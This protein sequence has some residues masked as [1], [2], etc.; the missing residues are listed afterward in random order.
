MNTS[1]L[2]R[3]GILVGVVVVFSVVASPILCAQEDAPKNLGTGDIEGTW[4][5]WFRGNGLELKISQYSG[6]ESAIMRMADQTR[7]TLTALELTPAL[8]GEFLLLTTSGMAGTFHLEGRLLHGTFAEGTEFTT[9]TLARSMPD[10]EDLFHEQIAEREARS[11]SPNSTRGSSANNLKQLGL[12]LKMFANESRGQLYP[13]LDSR[14]GQLMMAGEQ[15]FPEYV[16]DVTVYIS[17]A[18][19]DAQKLKEQ[20]DQNPLSVIG[21]HSYWYLGYVVT[22]EGAGLALVEAYRAAVEK[23]A[24]PNEDLEVAGAAT[25]M[26]L[27]EGVER[28]L[29]TDIN[30][31][32]S[33]ARIQSS[34][35]IMIERPELQSGGS[36]VLFMDGHVEFIKYPGKF[37]M[38]EKFIQALQSLDALK[39]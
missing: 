21:D 7:S 26:R 19:P 33:A 18:H 10:V 1:Q 32:S 6:H 5:G 25:I 38:T 24:V 34:L 31:A 16:T 35:H 29:I 20:A 27:R 22:D 37:P 39:K 15:V 23:G 13:R 36:N 2:G 28:F 8:N 3:W 17:P 11:Q 30:D 14:P 12:I 9:V 4:Y